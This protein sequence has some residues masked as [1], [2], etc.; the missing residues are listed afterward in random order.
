MNI[1]IQ[2]IKFETVNGK[3]VGKSFSFRLDPK[4]MAKYKTEATVRRRIE[5]HVAQSGVF[6]R[7]ELKELKYNMKE[8]LEEWKRQLPIVEA[9]ELA[10]LQKSE[11][12]PESRITPQR[13]VS[14]A[15]NEI[16][17]FGSNAQGMHLGGAAK[18]AAERFGA[19]MGQGHGPQGM[20]YAIDT[21]SGMED[22]KT[23]IIAFKQY[24]SAHTEKHF[25]VTLI[26][27][28][29]AGY[30]PSDVAPLF[31]S[32]KDL[33]NVSLPAEFWNIIGMPATA[34]PDYD[35]ERFAGAQD[36]AYATALQEL[37]DGEKRNHWIWYIFPQQKGLGHSLNSEYYGLTG[38]SEA[39]AYLAHPVLGPRLRECC[40]ALLSHKGK[41]TIDQIMGSNIDVL[42]LQTS[43]NL[44]NRVAPND[45]FLE[46]LQAFY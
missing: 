5:Q 38:A 25:F 43:M 32:F 12:S 15:P 39:R 1:K 14:L 8:F 36:K 10:K 30:Q 6:K 22:M 35:L 46:V 9:E 11:N 18:T 40:Q 20:S 13:I 21:M 45:I 44:F 26:G 17:V 27:C 28:G 4:E 34:E 19:V 31:A 42:K 16:F 41:R 29:I 24:T 23:D 2:V 37:R 3:K 7:S 33:T